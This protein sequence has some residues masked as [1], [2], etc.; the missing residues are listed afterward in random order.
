VTDEEWARVFAAFGPRVPDPDELARRIRNPD[1][2]APGM[3]L[4]RHLDV[5]DRLA[6]ISCPTLVCAGRLD[7]V[8]PVAAA[9]EIAGALPP[10]V[11]RLAVVEGAGHFPW[12]DRPDAY[13]PLITSFV[14]RRR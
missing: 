13:W 6:R 4:L 2:G 5:V 11:G 10:G 12:L 14:A 8:T 7:P 3:E 9:Q 1:L